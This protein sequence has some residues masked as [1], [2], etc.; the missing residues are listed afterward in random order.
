ML[1]L[2]SNNILTE[3]NK[4]IIDYNGLLFICKIKAILSFVIMWM[5][6]EKLVFH[7][8]SL[9]KKDKCHVIS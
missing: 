2:S 7:K 1:F 9:M 3:Q 6:L 4:S 8:A 5:K